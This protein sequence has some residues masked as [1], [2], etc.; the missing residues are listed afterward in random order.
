MA[1]RH[2]LQLRTI[3]ES[4]RSAV[5]SLRLMPAEHRA[6][7]IAAMRSRAT[8]LLEPLRAEIGPDADGQVRRELDLTIE[9][10]ERAI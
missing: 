9:E 4:Y 5:R 8:A 1:P 10:I 6:D 2:L 3:R 7:A